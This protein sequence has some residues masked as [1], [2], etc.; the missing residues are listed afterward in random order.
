MNLSW[1]TLGRFE[2]IM[3]HF[4]DVSNLILLNPTNYFLD[5]K[6]I[7]RIN[8]NVQFKHHFLKKGI[9]TTLHFNQLIV[10]KAHNV[11]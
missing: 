9:M 11:P 2:P 10:I 8:S 3:K 6:I 7:Y 5:L 1:K 4:L